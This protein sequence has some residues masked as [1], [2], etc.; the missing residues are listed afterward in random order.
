MIGKG[1]GKQDL[2][3]IGVMVKNGKPPPDQT[4]TT[5]H[6]CRTGKKSGKDW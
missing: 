1:G 5:K 3:Q 4:K 2:A 6:F